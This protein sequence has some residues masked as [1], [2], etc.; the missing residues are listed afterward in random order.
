MA[1][2]PTVAAGVA[3]LLLGVAILIAAEGVVSAVFGL[4]LILFGIRMA[5]AAARAR[6]VLT[7]SVVRETGDLL[8]HTYRAEDIAEFYVARAP[9]VVPWKT[10]WMRLN[11]GE[12]RALQQVRVLEFA[13]DRLTTDLDRAASTMN[14]WLMGQRAS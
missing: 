8:P 4:V 3:S 1:H 12:A 13:R 10:I 14:R 5:S 7:S 2:V 6:V 9:H 11:S